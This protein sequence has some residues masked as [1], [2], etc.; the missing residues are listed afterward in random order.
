[1]PT[2]PH[3]PLATRFG[4]RRAEILS[5]LRPG[6]GTVAALAAQLG[7]TRNAVRS[8]L[9]DLERRGLVTRKGLLPGKRRP[10]ELYELTPQ[11]AELLAQPADAVLSAILTALKQAVSPAKLRE[12]LESGG[13]ALAQ[14]FAPDDRA[15][16]LAKRV[17]E[18]VRLLKNLGGSPALEKTEEGFCIRSRTCPLA[19]V[20]VEHPET[21]ELMENL[22]GRIIQAPVSEHCLRNGKSQCRFAVSANGR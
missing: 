22:L 17:R 5:L 21:C 19:A 9:L 14:R 3:L 20:V 11:A 13:A 4:A 6:G 18:A 15:Q 10:H 8:H 2:R 7:L 12:L 16:P 1:M